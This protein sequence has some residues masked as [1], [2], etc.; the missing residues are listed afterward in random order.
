[1]S[2]CLFCIHHES[3]HTDEEYCPCDG[4][5]HWESY[6]YCSFHEDRISNLEDMGISYS[7]GCENYVAVSGGDA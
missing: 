6:S 4:S 2:E 5:Y 7:Y 3:R 1:M